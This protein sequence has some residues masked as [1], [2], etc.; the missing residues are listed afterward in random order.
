MCHWVSN[1]QC[2][3]LLLSHCVLPTLCLLPCAGNNRILVFP[4]GSTVATVVCGQGGSFTS[5]T[6]NLGGVSAS[7]LS[8]PVGVAVDASG[9][10]FATPSGNNRML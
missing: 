3:T 8:K 6:A 10:L 7:S 2:A 9:G 4:F 5:S 1:V